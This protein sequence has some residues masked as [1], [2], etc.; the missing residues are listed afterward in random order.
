MNVNFFLKKRIYRVD[1]VLL[2]II[3]FILGFGG[4]KVRILLEY[5]GSM[6]IIYSIYR[7]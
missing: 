6:K 7:L 4:V 3:R 2:I 5:F 1:E